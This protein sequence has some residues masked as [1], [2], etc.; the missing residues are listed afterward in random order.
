MREW[1]RERMKLEVD[2]MKGAEEYA[3]GK[4][5]GKIERDWQQGRGGA[6]K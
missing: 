4:G 2:R 6:R 1:E 5:E 3:E